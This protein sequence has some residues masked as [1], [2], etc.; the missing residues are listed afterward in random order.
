MYTNMIWYTLIYIHVCVC[1]CVRARVCCVCECECA[2]ERVCECVCVYVRACVCGVCVCVSVYVCMYVRVFDC[3]WCCATVF[4]CTGTIQD[5]RPSAVISRKTRMGWLQ[6][7]QK[8]LGGLAAGADTNWTYIYIHTH[9]YTH[10]YTH[11]C[12]HIHMKLYTTHRHTQHTQHTHTHSY[13]HTKNAH[14][15]CEGWSIW[16]ETCFFVMTNLC[17]TGEGNLIFFLFRHD[18]IFMKGQHSWFKTPLFVTKWWHK[19]PKNSLKCLTQKLFK[20]S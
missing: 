1:V 16:D 18:I 5:W 11:I 9:I 17:F 8:K 20:V 19:S 2:W 4:L 3:D 7:A 13:K 15:I 14:M 10:T 12:I 6:N